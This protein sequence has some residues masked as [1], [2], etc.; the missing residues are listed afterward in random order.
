MVNLPTVVMYTC[1]VCGQEKDETLFDGFPF[2]R[3]AIHPT[4]KM[5]R[6]QKQVVKN[7]KMK[8]RRMRSIFPKKNLAV[9]LAKNGSPM[10]EVDTRANRCLSNGRVDNSIYKSTG[11]TRG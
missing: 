7:H 2:K 10:F 9:T 8:P 1:H 3:G 6:N 5:C 11:L 4:C